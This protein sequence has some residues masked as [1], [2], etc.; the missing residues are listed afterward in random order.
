MPTFTIDENNQKDL[1]LVQDIMRSS[2]SQGAAGVMIGLHLVGNNF[3]MSFL[4]VDQTS[5]ASVVSS[6]QCFIVSTT[7][8]FQSAVGTRLGSLKR[9]TDAQKKRESEEGVIKIALLSSVGLGLASSIVFYATRPLAPLLLS[10]KHNG[11][12]IA[13]YTSEYFV[14]VSVTLSPIAYLTILT[15]GNI[16]YQLRSEQNKANFLLASTASYRG[17]SLLF[18]WILSEPLGFKVQGIGYGSAIAAWLT[19]ALFEHQ[20]LS[21]TKIYQLS[22]LFTIPSASS[23]WLDFKKDA[24]QLALQRTTEWGNLFAITS[25]ISRWSPNELSAIEP[26]IQSMVLCNLFTLGIAQGLMYDAKNNHAEKEKEKSKNPLSEKYM[27]LL[28]KDKKLFVFGVGLGSVLATISTALLLSFR[29][30]T[31][32]LFIGTKTTEGID[33]EL[34]KTILLISALSLSPDAVRQ[35]SSGVIRGWGLEEMHHTTKTNL[36]IMTLVG[37]PLGALYGFLFNNGKYAT[38]LFAFRLLTICISACVNTSYFKEVYA[39]K[40]GQDN[41]LLSAVSI[42]KPAK[43]TSKGV[44]ITPA[45]EKSPLLIKNDIESGQKKSD[46]GSNQT[47]NGMQI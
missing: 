21:E 47:T 44:T 22:K 1:D 33:L 7:F 2:I 25:I 46:Y 6:L 11:K 40:T 3:L 37:V 4:G 13:K 42:F 32:N 26:A 39:A 19:F 17:L 28:E 14:P 18:S 10:D 23:L 24:L 31:I 20:F 29:N 36:L 43:T 5:A 41:S 34:A 15:N 35:I 12:Q 45:P 16:L 8:G 38:P 27:G 9:Q 30:Q